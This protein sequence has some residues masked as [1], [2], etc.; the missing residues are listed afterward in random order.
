MPCATINPAV[1]FRVG[2]Q[3]GPGAKSE[4][5]KAH[6]EVSSSAMA[7]EINW[8]YDP[9][10]DDAGDGPARSTQSL[11]WTASEYIDH[12]Q[13][14]KWFLLLGVGTLAV[15]GIVYLL[16]KDYFA[17]GLMVVLGVIV[18][19]FAKRQPRQL[20]YELSSEGLKIDK[21]LYPFRS[22]KSFSIVQDGPLLSLNLLPIKRLIPPISAYFDAGD[23][24]KILDILGDRLPYE[25]HK[26]DGVER[27]TRRLRF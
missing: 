14:P 10:S 25:D 20:T 13:G 6:Y 1:D 18:G 26:L 9:E 27:L 21:K 4:F 24:E 2:S 22:F 8:K 19:I 16:T 15:A 12:Q 7:D 5:S 23:H 11:S 17:T 3:S